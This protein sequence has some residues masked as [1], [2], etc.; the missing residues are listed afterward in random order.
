[1]ALFINTNVNSLV[2]QNSLNKSTNSLQKSLYRLSTG[3]RINQSGDDA[4]GLCVAE[5]LES[6]IRAN[7]R[8]MSN[9]QDGLNMMYITEGGMTGV[10]EDLQRIRELCLQA[11]NGIYSP[12][13]KQTLMNEIKERLENIDAIANTTVFN[14]MQLTNGSNPEVILQAGAG[15]DA[16]N[17]TIDITSAMTNLLC[18]ALGISLDIVSMDE[19]NDGPLDPDYVDPDAGYDPA[20]PPKVNGDNWTNEAIR[21]YIDKLDAAIDTISQNRSQLGAYQN[22]LESAAQNLT[23]MNEN[24]ERSKSQILDCDMAEESAN[25]VKYQILQQTS[26]TMLSQANQLPSIAISLLQNA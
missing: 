6:R 2:A 16:A 1:M 15:S 4:A 5:G 18:T 11:A 22:R 19:A 26:T 13:Q 21:A 24:Y 10:T 14:G 20:N 12:D 9:I 3:L 17:N 7:K 25:M 23:T 8:A